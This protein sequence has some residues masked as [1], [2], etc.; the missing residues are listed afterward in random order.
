[1]NKYKK[2][3]II[4][5]FVLSFVILIFGIIS[6]VFLLLPFLT[7]TSMGCLLIKEHKNKKKKVIVEINEETKLS[8]TDNCNWNITVNNKLVHNNCFKSK[9]K[10]RIKKRID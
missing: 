3:I 10:I 6:G 4:K 1:M 5:L 2:Q 9:N 8:K 7:S